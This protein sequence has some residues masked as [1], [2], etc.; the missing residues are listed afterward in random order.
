MLC[1]VFPQRRQGDEADLR[2]EYLILH[3]RQSSLANVPGT[4]S[5]LSLTPLH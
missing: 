3:H 5:S 2:A 1:H 4:S